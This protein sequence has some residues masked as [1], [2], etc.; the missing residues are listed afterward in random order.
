MAFCFQKV[1]ETEFFCFCFPFFYIFKKE[2]QWAK[3]LIAHCRDVNKIFKEGRCTESIP[4]VTK[5]TKFFLL[6]LSSPSHLQKK[7]SGSKRQEILE[8][9]NIKTFVATYA[10]N[11]CLGE[12]N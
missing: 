11:V 9:G 5:K 6:S 2:Q 12:K 10:L 3:S 1:K 7:E 8:R 4:L